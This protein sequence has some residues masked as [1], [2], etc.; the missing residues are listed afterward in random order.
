MKT[1]AIRKE[2]ELFVDI[3]TQVEHRVGYDEDVITELG[4]TFLGGLTDVFYDS[5]AEAAE[6]EIYLLESGSVTVS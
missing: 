2:T 6:T 3:H 1:Q 4:V 5:I